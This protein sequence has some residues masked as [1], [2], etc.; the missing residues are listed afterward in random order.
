MLL[1]WPSMGGEGRR[2]EG[3]ILL[4]LWEGTVSHV[5]SPVG[6]EGSGALASGRGDS[7]SFQTSDFSLISSME[8]NIL[9]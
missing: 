6:K 4:F 8:D 5:H 1:A 3:Y 2:Q 7:D 9:S